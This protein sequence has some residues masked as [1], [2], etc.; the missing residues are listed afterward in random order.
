MPFVSHVD[1]AAVEAYVNNPRGEI[2]QEIVKRANRVEE[3]AKRMVGVDT[4]ALRASIKTRV[5][6]ARAPRIEI[7][8]T[9]SYALMHHEGT[10]PHMIR[11]HLR[12]NLRFKVQGRVVYARE[13]FHP[14]TRPNRFLTIPLE[15]YGRG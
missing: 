7:G 6:P 10:R 13:V 12:R 2:F 15:R 3:A 1:G 4:G 11:P 8:A 9:R 14:G 5:V